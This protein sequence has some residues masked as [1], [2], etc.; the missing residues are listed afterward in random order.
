MLSRSTLKPIRTLFILV[1]LAGVGVASA[2]SGVSSTAIG[3]L[4]FLEAKY[5]DRGLDGATS[6]AASPDG[7][8]ARGNQIE[9][10][11][12]GTDATGTMPLPN[13]RGIWLYGASETVVGG[14]TGKATNCAYD[15]N[16]VAASTIGSGFS[17]TTMAID[18][19][20]TV[21]DTLI[22]TT[23]PFSAWT[24]AFRVMSPLA[25]ASL[26]PIMAFNAPAAS[27]DSKAALGY[28]A[29]TEPGC[30][31]PAPAAIDSVLV[32]REPLRKLLRFM[33]LPREIVMNEKGYRVY[34]NSTMSSI[35]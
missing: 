24:G 9:G 27:L 29:N 14:S 15:C 13:Q 35:C 20:A 33:Y 1:L 12:I 10:N 30:S 8:G 2:A 22:G 3:V 6:V 19:A 4:N 28:S 32:A 26:D 11:R 18:S 17:A 25:A 5:D 21:V 16:L 31:K 23:A 34:R 7:L